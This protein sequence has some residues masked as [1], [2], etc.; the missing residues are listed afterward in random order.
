MTSYLPESRILDVGK[1]HYSP[2]DPDAVIQT[3][4]GKRLVDSIA[5]CQQHRAQVQDEALKNIATSPRASLPAPKVTASPDT[6]AVAAQAFSGALEAEE[7]GLIT[8]NL[9]YTDLQQLTSTQ[10]QCL[11]Q[12]STIAIQ[13]QQQAIQLQQQVDS[14]AASM[15][16]AEST[17]NW[18]MFGLGIALMVVTFVAGVF[19]GGAADAALPE[20]AELVAGYAADSEEA[21]GGYEGI[22]AEAADNGI[23][24]ATESEATTSSSSSTTEAT[25]SSSSTTQSN[26]SSVRSTLQNISKACR[27]R[28]GRTLIRTAIGAAIGSPMLMKGI[29]DVKLS[30]QYKQLADAQ[31]EVGPAQASMHRNNMVNQF[32]QQELQ[33][34]GGI[35]REEV[36]DVGEVIETYASITSAI[37]QIAYGLANAT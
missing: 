33:R 29:V 26:T 3:Q 4:G 12:S 1:A 20:E 14:Y 2:T 10:S 35:I 5:S 13:K 9:S 19:T 37:R 21:I 7:H 31:R 22:E 36:N 34:E 30:D 25:Q 27:T 24:E 11:L 28:L 8:G 32:Y 18:V 6:L 17:V 16:S 23:G 15:S